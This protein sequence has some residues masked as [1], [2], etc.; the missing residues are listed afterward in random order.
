MPPAV[1]PTDATNKAQLDTAAG[2]KVAL[3]DLYRPM[4]GVWPAVDA[5]NGPLTADAGITGT[6]PST[7]GL[8]YY[9]WGAG[10][11]NT[12]S[13]NWVA[14]PS[15]NGPANNTEACANVTTP[16]GN[17]GSTGIGFACHIDFSFVADTATLILVYRQS[18]T[19]M[20]GV[21]TSYHEN[22]IFADH[23]G[24]MKQ[25]RGAPASW[26]NGSGG[27][28]VFYRVVTFK[29]ALRRE[30]RVWLSSNCW[31]MGVYIDTAASMT[32]APNRPVL[33]GSFGDSWGE[34]DGNVFQP[35]GGNG[36]AA[37]VTWP[38]GCSLLDSNTAL[39]YAMATG[40]AVIIGHQ[41]GTGWVVANGSGLTQS[42]TADG[43]TPFCS[44]G[45]VN[46]FWNTFGARSPMAGVFGGWNDGT[47]PVSAPITTNYQAQVASGLGRLI[48]KDSTMPILVEGIQCKTISPGDGRDQS[49]TGIKQ[50]CAALPANVIGFVDNIA[51]LNYVDLATQNFG[52]DGIHP[53]VKGGNHIGINRAKRSASFTIPR[54]RV[55]AMQAA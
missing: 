17:Y 4:L 30:F 16:R 45:Q 7:T 55:I 31:L 44:Q 1:N 53:T 13:Q 52:P 14:V 43:F 50:A 46:F 42:S 3:G 19:A 18:T 23:E 25:L 41:G 48:V 47:S 5:T 22:R 29:Q 9:S 33:M 32:K 21:T 39:Q 54:S 51:D 8:T 26:P 34:G 12:Q 10:L 37:G 6:A 49:N 40:F 11:F 2:G 15:S 20:P 36:S 28:Q 38:S 24:Q 27:N 35:F